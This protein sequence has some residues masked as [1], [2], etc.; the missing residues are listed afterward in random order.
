MNCYTITLGS[1]TINVSTNFEPLGNFIRAYFN[2]LPTDTMA[3]AIHID[4]CARWGWKRKSVSAR[5]G[6]VCLGEGA[7]YDQKNNIL[8][9]EYKEINGQLVLKNGTLTGNFSFQPFAPKHI[10]N[11]IFFK[12][13]G[14]AEHYYRFI[15][16]LVIQNIL[17]MLAARDQHIEI[18]SAAAVVVK[19]KGFVFAGLPGSGKTTTVRTLSEKMG[20]SIAAQNYAPFIDGFFWPFTEGQ[21][22]CSD[23]KYPIKAVYIVTHG[24]KFSIERLSPELAFSRLS[25]VNHATAELPTHSIFGSL[26]LVDPSWSAITAAESLRILCQ[27]TEVYQVVMDPGLTDF[28]QYFNNTYGA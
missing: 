19:D 24:S 1:S 3:D 8:Q 15:C 26:C 5:G 21:S 27:K 12:R 7:I 11:R 2:A 22:V 13:S 10:A 16:R 9:L 28:V 6:A 14:L 17:F 18:L 20:A 25:F 4:Y 23:K